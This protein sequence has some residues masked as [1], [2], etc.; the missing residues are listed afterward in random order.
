[1]NTEQLRSLQPTVIRILENALAKD[2]LSHAYLFVGEK[3]TCTLECALWLIGKVINRNLDENSE[4]ALS[5][6][7]RLE[8]GAYADC[9]ILD[10]LNKSIKKDEILSIQERFSKT[11]L[12]KA[13]W[14]AYILNGADN[15]TSEAC[16]SLLKFLEEPQPDTLA[17][18]ITD[19]LDHVLPTLVSRCQTLTFKTQPFDGCYQECLKKGMDELDSYFLAHLVHNSEMAI[20]ISETEGYQLAVNLVKGFVKNFAEDPSY[21]LFQIQSEGYQ[22]KNRSLER[23]TMNW[24]IELLS[25]FYRDCILSEGL[26]ESWYKEA[27]ERSRK[28]DLEFESLIRILLEGKDKFRQISFNPELVIDEMILKMKEVRKWKK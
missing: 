1:M 22:D 7:R 17:I 23:E 19:K 21:A 20:Q 3:G 25:L 9:L 14:K 18:L 24:F 12:E 11:A 8:E 6:I 26:K 10:G 4:E 13:G 16:N 2:K 28:E 5:N 27:V 15:A